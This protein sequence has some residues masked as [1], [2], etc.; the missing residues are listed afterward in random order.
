VANQSGGA[1]SSPSLN[2]LIVG[3]FESL[4]P[5]GT[6][7]TSEDAVGWLQAAAANLRIVYKIQGNILVT[8]EVPP[9][10]YNRLPG[11]N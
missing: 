6:G 10:A 7:W 2:P 9:S 3:L 8:G 5:E 4:P 1:S 11:G